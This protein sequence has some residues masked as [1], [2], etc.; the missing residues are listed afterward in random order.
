MR[1]KLAQI[2]RVNKGLSVCCIFR[3]ACIVQIF[4]FAQAC[5]LIAVSDLD[6]CFAWDSWEID[7]RRHQSVT[8]KKLP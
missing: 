3:H 4:L 8:I 6:F 2:M 7:T 1:C 5:F